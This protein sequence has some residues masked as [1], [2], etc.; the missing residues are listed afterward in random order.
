MA[1]HID[2]MRKNV[3]IHRTRKLTHQEEEELIEIT[4]E[5]MIEDDKMLEE[6]KSRMAP[7]IEKKVREALEKELEEGVEHMKREMM[8]KIHEER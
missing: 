5:Q 4:V 7:K 6:V 2:Q 1:E 3:N 8:A